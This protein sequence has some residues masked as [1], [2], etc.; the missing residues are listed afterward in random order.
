MDPQVVKISLHLSSRASA[1]GRYPVYFKLKNRATGEMCRISINDVTLL[2]SDWD[3]KQKRPFNDLI[4]ENLI[5]KVSELKKELTDF[6]SFELYKQWRKNPFLVETTYTDF[7]EFGESFKEREPKP[8]TRSSYETAMNSFKQVYPKLSVEDINYGMVRKYIEHC[9]DSGLTGNSIRAYMAALSKIY[10]TACRWKGIEP[11]KPFADPPRKN[12]TR[13]KY[14]KE[15]ELAA[16]LNY[17]LPEDEK[18]QKHLDLNRL[19][20]LLRGL[21]IIDIVSLKKSDYRDGYIYTTRRKNSKRSLS[22]RLTIKVF[23]AA[24][25]IISTY[26]GPTD[27]LLSFC[28]SNM[29]DSH[30]YYRYQNFLRV[31]NQW[32]DKVAHHLKLSKALRSKAIRHSFGTIA[33]NLFLNM[34]TVGILLGHSKGTGSTQAYVGMKAQDIVDDW[35]KKVISSVL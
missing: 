1:N 29:D 10:K 19:S 12:E 15:D 25:K 31:H 34:D 17:Q 20:F 23:P 7:Y 32:L 5:Q 22:P 9:Q 27:Y 4:Y 3:Y 30:Q 13:E 26:V 21:D 16:V 33:H 2:K 18:V 24:E 35:H 14:I 28:P 11:K 8:A 6:S